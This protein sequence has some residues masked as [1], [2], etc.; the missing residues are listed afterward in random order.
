MHFTECAFLNFVPHGSSEE[1]CLCSLH[2]T[3]FDHDSFDPKQFSIPPP[4]TD[5]LMSHFSDSLNFNS[6]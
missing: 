4:H 3:A 2:S 5:I 6:E 1:F